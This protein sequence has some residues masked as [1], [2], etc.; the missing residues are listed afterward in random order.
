MEIKRI[1][2]PTDFSEGS[3]VAVPLLADLVKKYGAKLYILHVI[4]DIATASG[5]YVPHTSMDEVYKDMEIAAGKELQKCCVEELRGH[6]DIERVTVKG[7][8][9][10]EIVK[11]IVGNGIDLLVMGTHGR[12]GLDRVLFGSTASK[13]VRNAPCPVLTVRVP[14]AK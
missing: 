3:L 5:W 6:K 9:H 4:Y 2:Y 8:P 1:L 10:E 7:I 11:F 14:S 13:A 12:K